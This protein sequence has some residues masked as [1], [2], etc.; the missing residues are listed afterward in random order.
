MLK[1]MFT[2]YLDSWIFFW[3][4]QFMDFNNFNCCHLLLVE[5]V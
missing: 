4:A 5:N 1:K 2:K 3:R